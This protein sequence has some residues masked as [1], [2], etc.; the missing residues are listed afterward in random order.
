MSK[1]AHK[2]K[3]VTPRCKTRSAGAERGLAIEPLFSLIAV[4]DGDSPPRR[5]RLCMHRSEPSP[6]CKNQEFCYGRHVRF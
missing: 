2:S 1:A 5:D 6:S 3:L 4:A